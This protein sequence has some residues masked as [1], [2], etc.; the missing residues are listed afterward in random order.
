MDSIEYTYLVE[1]KW[2]DESMERS[3]CISQSRDSVRREKSGKVTPDETRLE[4]KE[5]LWAKFYTIIYF[6]II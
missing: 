2:G 4:L 3:I 1:I 5:N 6:Y